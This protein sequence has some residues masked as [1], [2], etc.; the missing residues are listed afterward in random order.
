[1]RNYGHYEMR[2]VACV[3]FGIVVMSLQS[4]Y[5]MIDV[6]KHQRQQQRQMNSVPSNNNT[7][8]TISTIKTRPKAGTKETING[9]N[10]PDLTEKDREETECIKRKIFEVQIRY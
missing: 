1:M 7:M 10:D 2:A 5:N 8:V 4:N 3:Q 9:T 6:N